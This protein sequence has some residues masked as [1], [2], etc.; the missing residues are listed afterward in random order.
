MDFFLGMLLGSFIG[1]GFF[2]AIYFA[3]RFLR[4][5]R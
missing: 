1:I 4:S 5:F 2:A 3:P